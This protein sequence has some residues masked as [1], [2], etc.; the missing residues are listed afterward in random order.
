MKVFI[1]KESNSL[2]IGYLQSN[3]KQTDSRVLYILRK[4]KDNGIISWYAD[5]SFFMKV[6]H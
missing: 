2:L 3:D 6:K 4:T 5:R 1:P